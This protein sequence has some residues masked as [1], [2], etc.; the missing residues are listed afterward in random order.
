MIIKAL[1]MAV[2][3]NESTLK[4]LSSFQM[5]GD[6]IYLYWI[7]FRSNLGGPPPPIEGDQKAPLRVTLF[8]IF[9]VANIVFMCYRASLTSELSTR[10]PKMPFITLNDLLISD[11]Q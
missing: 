5:I 3:R 11:Y 1:E 4:S 9:F 10:K 7:A 6:L 8:S 2:N